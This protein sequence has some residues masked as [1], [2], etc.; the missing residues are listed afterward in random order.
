MSRRL[1]YK[2]QQR[3]ILLNCIMS[4]A[5]KHMT[6]DDLLYELRKDGHT[7]GQ[8]T[9]YRNLN[10]LVESGIIRKYTISGTEGAY[11]EY[12]PEE[13]SETSFHLQCEDCGELMHFHCE[14]MSEIHQHVYEGHALW[15]NPSKTVFYGKCPGCLKRSK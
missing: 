12:L 1:D 6:V 5:G 8:T 2:T 10:K 11:Y 15:I 3:K 4:H 14:A 13:N 7:I 9:V